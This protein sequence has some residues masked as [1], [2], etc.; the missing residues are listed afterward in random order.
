[1]ISA[2]V[3]L[4]AVIALAAWIGRLAWIAFTNSPDD[5]PAIKAAYEG[6]LGK[7]GPNASVV[8]FQRCGTTFPTRSTPAYRQYEVVVRKHDGEMVTRTVGI[9]AGLFSSGEVAE[10]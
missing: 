7:A 3:A 2:L 5:G 4:V 10:F 8:S 9:A 1:M 6:I